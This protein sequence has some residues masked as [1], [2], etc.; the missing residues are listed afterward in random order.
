MDTAI[1]K[2]NIVP[3]QGGFL[4]IS[5]LQHSQP[6]PSL[7]SPG[8]KSTRS[9]RCSRCWVCDSEGHTMVMEN[10][11]PGRRVCFANNLKMKLTTDPKLKCNFKVALSELA[12]NE[13][14]VI[15]LPFSYKSP[16]PLPRPL[17]PHLQL[18]ATCPQL[19]Q[20]PCFQ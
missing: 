20:V 14:S 15:L 5:D 16:K 19:S 18:H 13:P 17:S 1:N 9:F 7:P 2:T 3:A 6:L 4:S 11:L 10:Q 8:D 12:L